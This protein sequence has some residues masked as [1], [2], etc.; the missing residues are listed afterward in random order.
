[1]EDVLDP[2]DHDGPFFLGHVQH[3][4]DAQ[5]PVAVSRAQIAEP[6]MKSEPI[7]RPLGDKREGANSAGV[8]VVM[9]DGRGTGAAAI[10]EPPFGIGPTLSRVE[11]S[12][13]K[14]FVWVALS[15]H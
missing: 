13:A 3:A 8:I 14:Q 12:G 15:P 4:L 11:Q 2:V 5:Q 1:M 7:E 6:T 10:L 9:I